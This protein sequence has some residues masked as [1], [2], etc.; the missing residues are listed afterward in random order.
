MIFAGLQMKQG[1]KTIKKIDISLLDK[2]HQCKSLAQM[3]N[4]HARSL[5]FFL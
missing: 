2:L 5:L 4:H 3:Q 1:E